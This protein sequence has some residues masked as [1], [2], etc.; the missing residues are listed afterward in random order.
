M[1]CL[2]TQKI[3]G[4]ASQ[5]EIMAENCK[6]AMECGKLKSMAKELVDIADKIS[7]DMECAE[8]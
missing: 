4:I 1:I 6:T 5:M 2:E 3:Y 7:L 8:D